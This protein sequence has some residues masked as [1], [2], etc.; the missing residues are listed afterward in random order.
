MQV[1]AGSVEREIPRCDL[2]KH[3]KYV[4]SMMEFLPCAGVTAS[5]AEAWGEDW[6]VK[7]TSSPPR[8]ELEKEVFAD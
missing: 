4:A 8:R 3:R 2:S 6:Q 5:H 7:R 1:A